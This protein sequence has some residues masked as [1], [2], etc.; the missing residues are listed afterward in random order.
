MSPAPA[1]G[2]RTVA[3][4]DCGTTSTRAFLAEVDGSATRVLEDLVVPVDLTDA[5]TTGKLDREAMDGVVA[6]LRGIREAASAY[7]IREIRAVGTSGLRE[8]SNADVLLERIRHEL[9]IDIE[10]IDA[11]E[12]SR[13]YWQ[14][15]RVLCASCGRTLDGDQLMIEVGGGGSCIGLIREGDLVQAVDEHFG[16]Q[17]IVDILEDLQDSADFAISVDRLALGA[18]RMML[19]RLPPS[20]PRRLVVTGSAARRVFAQVTG[21]EPDDIDPLDPALIDRWVREQLAVSNHQRAELAG[22]RELADTL[23]AGGCLVRHLAAISGA[24]EVLVPQL[25]LR[26][27][28]LADLL[29]GSTGPHHLDARHLLAEARQLVRRYG[30]DLAYAEN[31]AELSAQIFDQCRELHGLGERERAMLQF[32]ALVHDIGAYINVRNRHKHTMYLIAASDLAGLTVLEKAMVANV[33]RYHRKSPPEPHH[34]E[35]TALPRRERVVVSHLAAILRLAY[36]LDVERDQRIRRV[37]C[38]VDAGRLLI[39]VDRRQIA[40]E[41]WSMRGKAQLFEE[42][43]GLK[44]VVLP[45]EET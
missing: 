29:P 33:A 35:F 14:A 27:G 18:A 36:A 40:L 44:V 30:A 45:R 22:S 17:R 39:R 26:D 23:L 5:F 12:E 21:A 31:T 43:F 11:A 34:Q 7:A 10:V 9:G 41:Q 19:S 4:V 32:A 28:L 15:L 3:V 1:T 13:L 20:G 8:A 2:P 25:T 42:I 38:T 6:A 37:V 24:T 16:T